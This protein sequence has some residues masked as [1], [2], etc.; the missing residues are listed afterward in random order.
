[1]SAFCL[2]FSLFISILIPP[3]SLYSLRPAPFL[4]F[5]LS[6]P[7]PSSLPP[8][9]G[10]TAS[11]NAS[12]MNSLTSLGTL[13]GL[14]GATV[15]LNNINALAG[16]VNSEYSPCHQP[17]HLHP[18]LQPST[19]H[20]SVLITDRLDAE[21]WSITAT[22]HGKSHWGGFLKAAHFIKQTEDIFSLKTTL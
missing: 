21:R 20:C 1:M 19:P 14:A 12:A 8:A 9:A 16:S 6:I 2:L 10:T 15:G 22:Q 17:L 11:S 3:F 7:P 5:P 4:L 18:H 13:Q